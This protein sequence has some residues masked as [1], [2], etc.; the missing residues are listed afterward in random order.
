MSAATLGREAAIPILLVP[1]SY[2]QM[3]GLVVAFIIG[4]IALMVVGAILAS[5]ARKKRQMALAAWARS[6]GFHYTPDEVSTL[7]DRFYGFE[8]LQQGSNRYGYNV[9][10]G[11]YRARGTWAFDY[12]Y[13]T[14]SRDSKGNRTTHH[15]HF[16]AV[17]VDSGLRLKPLSLRGEHFF[18]RIK[19]VFGFDDID[20]ES[21]Q[22]SREFWV[23]AEDKRWAYDVIHQ[24][25]M[26][27][28]LESPRFDLQ[29]NGPYVIANRGS[30]FKPQEFDQALQVAHGILDRL[31]RDIVEQLRV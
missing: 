18:D 13:E 19:G 31:P 14:Y 2:G 23:R 21:A 6:N 17:V 26:E 1:A 4:I 22:F 29:M 15:H 20:F 27:F 10:R 25:T 3:P 24:G 12:H 7:E 16:S 11:T 5:Q 30:R 28:L 9:M 8:C